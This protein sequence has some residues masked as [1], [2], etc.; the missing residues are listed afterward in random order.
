MAACVF[1][2]PEVRGGI[3]PAVRPTGQPRGAPV[4]VVIGWVTLAAAGEV[5]QAC[6]AA[7][8]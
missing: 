3:M 6:P 2:L 1:A 8:G 7:A 4:E 5:V